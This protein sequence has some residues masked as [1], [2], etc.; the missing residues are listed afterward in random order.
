MK[1]KKQGIKE[2]L[3]EFLSKE[4]TALVPSSYDIVGDILIFI[5]FPEEL[6]KKEKKIAKVFLDYFKNINVVLKKTGQYSGKFRTPKMK[7]LAGEKRKETIHKENNVRIKLDVEKVYFSP[8]TSNERLRLSKQIKKNESILVMFSGSAVL[9]IVLS[10]NTDAKEIY[11]V[12]INPIAHKY[13]EENIGLNKI[14]NITLYNGD[15]D[16]I[17]PTIKKKFDRVAMPLPK[18]GEDYLELAISKIKKNGIIHF[19]DFLNEKDFPLAKEKV[20]KACDNIKAKFKIIDL[21]KC[22]QYAPYTY[23]VCVDFKV[24]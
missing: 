16:E 2:I 20:K 1:T 17:L 10:K 14:S 11:A 9:P 4:E 7:V 23:R 15:V 5:D 3:A 13:A 22:G 12:E 8:R 24:L 6:E 18:G 19:Y 21:V